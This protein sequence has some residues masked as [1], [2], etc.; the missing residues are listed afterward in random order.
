MRGGV[1]LLDSATHTTKMPTQTTMMVALTG[2]M[3][4]R[5]S[6]SGNPGKL[7]LVSALF[8]L[9]PNGGARV[10]NRETYL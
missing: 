6:Q 7:D 5:S 1:F 9:P 8:T 10:P 3:I 4:L 2:T